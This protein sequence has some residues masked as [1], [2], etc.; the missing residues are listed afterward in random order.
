MTT[1]YNHALFRQIQAPIQNTL[2]KL[3]DALEKVVAGSLPASQLGMEEDIRMVAT[4]LGILDR[5]VLS[6]L[7]KS[8][9]GA[10]QGVNHPDRFGWDH[11][12]VQT[13]ARHLLD[14]VRAFQQHLL[15]L[16]SGGDELHVR[17]WPLWKKM[18]QAMG[19]EEPDIYSLFEVDPNFNDEQFRARSAESIQE[20]VLGDRQEGTQSSGIYGRFVGAIGLVEVARTN[21]EMETG[22]Q[23]AL[24]EL[25]RLYALRHKR[26]Y[27]A[28]WLILR[29]RLSVG[30]MKAGDLLD[31]RKEW[32]ALLRDASI[33]IRMFGENHRRIKVD[34]LY[35]DIQPLLKPW[36]EEWARAHPILAELDRRF[37]LSVFWRAVDEILND[38]QDG[39]AAQFF[40]RQKEL[41]ESL[42]QLKTTWNR[43]VSSTEE[44]R[45]VALAPFLRNLLLFLPKKSWF[46]GGLA[47][48]LFDGLKATGDKLAERLKAKEQ[49]S[50]DETIAFEV[51]ATLLL[52]EE[53][54]ERRARWAQELEIRIQS[55][56][57]R[58][59]LALD[60]RGS[61]VRSLAPLRW[62][63][64][65]RER[66][67]GIAIQT[68]MG[69]V[70]NHVE[71][72]TKALADLSRG[73]DIEEIR[74]RLDELRG[75]SSLVGK[76]LLTLRQ[77]LAGQMAL[78]FIP[79]IEKALAGQDSEENL[80]VLA[81]GMASL[82]GFLM[83]SK[84]G[85]VD[86][87]SS[88][89]SGFDALFG[90]GAFQR[91]TQSDPGLVS[92]PLAPVVPERA[93]PVAQEED[94]EERI[95]YPTESVVAPSAPAP[96]RNLRSE[97]L[98]EGAVD[99]ARDQE[100]VQVFLEEAEGALD[101]IRA[102]RDVLLAS[103]LDEEAWDTLK[104]QFHT[105]KGSGK[106]SG[107]MALGEVAF[108]VED[109]LSDAIASQEAYA[110]PLDRFVALAASR[111]A[112]WYDELRQG[113]P[114]VRVM[115]L[116][117]HEAMALAVAPEAEAQ[118]EQAGLSEEGDW[119]QVWPAEEAEE[120]PEP[121]AQAVPG[122]TEEDMA[123]L[124]QIEAQQHADALATQIIHREMD[125][126]WEFPAIHLAAHT[127]A[128]LV[129][130]EEWQAM[131]AVGRSVERASET[132]SVAQSIS[133][134]LWFLS[135]SLLRDMA[136]SLAAGFSC[137]DD[138]DNVVERLYEAVGLA[139]E[140]SPYPEDEQSQGLAV[141]EGAG[142]EQGGAEE[143]TNHVAS[144][145]PLEGESV[146][147]EEQT[148]PAPALAG[149]E[150]WD[151]IVPEMAEA[152]VLPPWDDGQESPV[153]GEEAAE[154]VVEP[155][156]EELAL[157]ASEQE[158][159]EP[160]VEHPEEWEAAAVSADED[161]AVSGYP[162]FVL[163]GEP[164]LAEE[165][166]PAVEE[167]TAN[168]GRVGDLFEEV[169]EYV[170]KEVE[171]VSEREKA[172]N[173]VFEGI[174]EVQQGFAK[175]ARA[176]I[177]LHEMDERD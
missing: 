119:A 60:G 134:D 2:R 15:D 103:P 94:R 141:E 57:H 158:Q 174:D 16:A 31:Q 171:E 41:N 77:P 42:G 25:N 90:P 148:E 175:M 5:K 76:V 39:A 177:A 10:V 13:V 35:Q 145:L 154:P 106:I 26:F 122:E 137:P 109:R 93:A 116:D 111:L 165:P 30:L 32:L 36:P 62:D 128:S 17:M 131:V 169:V 100:I 27:Q 147:A 139:A 126:N 37:G 52:L 80:A 120:V 161:V 78:G 70:S 105:L 38:S 130:D 19:L 11:I 97:L 28:Y 54:V 20:M 55:R 157:D 107:L 86:V 64:K 47:D 150:E 159:K 24:D 12:Q 9:E 92:A 142:D 79:F 173:T 168:D 110:E 71:K 88:L 56:A 117:V 135:L 6:V 170:I 75:R 132:A 50:V 96:A 91:Q 4:N 163:D 8:V 67:A 3:D 127:L 72:I 63:S 48:P 45:K 125:G 84:H 61:E 58:L 23:S 108:W 83:S 65:W 66:Q 146:E 156:S 172:W 85:D 68:A 143:S 98:N 81:K 124:I 133:D 14:L 43:F 136:N 114:E 151:S 49:G 101:E 138:E 140:P 40:S 113:S 104:R 22:I 155:A 73:E 21:K 112:G 176:L 44:Q 115:A 153:S 53:L 7:A 59:G 129:N 121:E 51:A 152:V 87:E 118:E 82:S 89:A 102:Q 160:L 29:A 74:E 166:E 33:Q 164:G 95:E 34:R 167:A 1:I 99:Q 149:D 46:P 162:V 69:L 18:N 144:E 123:R